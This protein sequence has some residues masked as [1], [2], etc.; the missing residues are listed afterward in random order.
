VGVFRDVERDSYDELVRAQMDRPSAASD[1][2]QLQQLVSSGDTW[3][4]Y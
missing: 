2:G 3:E 1:G 4:I